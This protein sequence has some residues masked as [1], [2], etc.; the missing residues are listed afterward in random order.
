MRDLMGEI[1]SHLSSTSPSRQW[2]FLRLWRRFTTT[3][4]RTRSL[5]VDW[6][7]K[8]DRMV[9]QYA[10]RISNL[11]YNLR[12]AL[13]SPSSSPNPLLDPVIISTMIVANILSPHYALSIETS[14]D[15]AVERCVT[16]SLPDFTTDSAARSASFSE[17]KIIRAIRHVERDICRT[18]IL[19]HIELKPVLEGSP[20]DG[21]TGLHAAD[22][23]RIRHALRLVTDLMERLQWSAW[24]SCDRK[25]D[26]DE[27]CSTSNLAKPHKD[28]PD[29]FSSADD[30]TAT[31][32]GEPTCIKISN[33]ACGFQGIPDSMCLDKSLGA[34]ASQWTTA[35]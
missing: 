29:A 2:W 21:H 28:S 23:E 6:R 17:Q 32:V 14:F 7:A 35:A 10:R 22:Q 31:A 25:C 8:T 4:Q 27:V 16:F 5:G 13:V 34:S 18:L 20:S 15:A 9:Q 19:V 11:H 12:Q 3:E 24:K 30:D 26:V 33:W 1:E